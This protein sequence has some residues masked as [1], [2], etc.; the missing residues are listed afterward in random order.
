MVLG[1][2]RYHLDIEPAVAVCKVL[3]VPPLHL[4]LG[5]QLFQEHLPLVLV[6][7]V[8][9]HLRHAHQLAGTVV[10]AGHHAEHLRHDPAAE[11]AAVRDI[12]LGGNQP[13][14]RVVV[15]QHG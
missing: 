14:K 1:H 9:D 13:E 3:H 12:A 7:Q 11:Q 8:V 2:L 5:V 10:R 6:A 15:I 4:H